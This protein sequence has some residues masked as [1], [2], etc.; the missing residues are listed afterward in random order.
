MLDIPLFFV[1]GNHDSMLELSDGGQ[2]AYPLGGI[3]MHCQ[4][5]NQEGLI[6]AGVEGSIRYKKQG[7]FQYSQ[8]EM[9]SHVLSLTPGLL[10][11][12]I[13]YDRYLDVFVTHAPPWGIHDKMDLPH[14]GIKAF[15]WLLQVF[16]PAYH[17]HGH[18]HVYRPDATTETRYRETTVINTYGYRITKIKSFLD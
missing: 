9:W 1:R 5:I 6:I 18:T 2:R 4:I 11:N 7:A 8:G 14:Q 10:F 13:R 12:R 3:N 15:R 16:K 17:F